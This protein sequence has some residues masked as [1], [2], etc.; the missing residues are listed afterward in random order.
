MEQGRQL[1][2]EYYQDKEKLKLLPS[3]GSTYFLLVKSSKKLYE[4]F[5][6]LYQQTL[7]SLIAISAPR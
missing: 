3:K 4:N 1:D 5:F 2:E 7:K 6:I